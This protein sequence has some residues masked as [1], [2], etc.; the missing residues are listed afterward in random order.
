ME[1][2][3]DLINILI[4]IP[5]F[6]EDDATFVKILIRW[7]KDCELF[8]FQ[9]FSADNIQETQAILDS[10]NIDIMVVSYPLAFKMP[11][12]DLS[13]E[14]LGPN[15]TFFISLSQRQGLYVYVRFEPRLSIAWLRYLGGSLVEAF[16]RN[17][18][19][20]PGYE[21]YVDITDLT[22]T[23]EFKEFK[24]QKGKKI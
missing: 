4:A 7:L 11:N 22:I 14:E 21:A 9:I 5:V 8:C 13:F 18:A 15:D 10:K 24:R 17:I 2:N 3:Q 1:N 19:I 16:P 12:G 23:D 6:N 20:M